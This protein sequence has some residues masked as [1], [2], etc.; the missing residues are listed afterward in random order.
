[1]YVLLGGIKPLVDEVMGRKATRIYMGECNWHCP[2]CYVPEVLDKAQCQR[3]N[4]S[5]TIYLLQ[6]MKGMDAVEITGGEPTKQGK[7]LEALCRACKAEGWLVKVHTNGSNPGVVGDLVTENLVDVLSIDVKAP[8]NDKKMYAFVTGN[9]ADPQK[10]RESLG[11]AH[12]R[13]F[14]GF[15]EALIPVLPG[16]ND[17]VDVIS[18]ICKD[19]SYCDSLVLRGF[20]PRHDLVSEE[21]KDTDAPSHDTLLKLAKA[22]RDALYNVDMVVIESVEKGKEII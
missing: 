10:V 8:L 22:G 3:V 19:I 17:K 4:L 13:S 18:K 20:D 6:Q 2:Y 11:L 14:K 15:F 21:W 12:L 7:E 5:E 1:M 16:V 9:K